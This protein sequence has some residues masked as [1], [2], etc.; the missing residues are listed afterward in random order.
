MLQL[1]RLVPFIRTND[2]QIPTYTE[3]LSGPMRPSEARTFLAG[4]RA[5][6]FLRYLR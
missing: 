1:T 5:G 4:L 2:G 3:S 6:F